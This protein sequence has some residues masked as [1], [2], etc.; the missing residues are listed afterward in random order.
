[1]FAS[2]RNQHYSLKINGEKI[3]KN[4]PIF[5]KKYSPINNV[6]QIVKIRLT[7]CRKRHG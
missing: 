5:S 3:T 7:I 1:M 6:T 4:F 2:P